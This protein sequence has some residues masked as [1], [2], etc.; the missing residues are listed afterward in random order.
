[1]RE[2]LAQAWALLLGAQPGWVLVAVVLYIVAWLAGGRR[3]QVVV[4]ALG[5]HVAFLHAALATIAGVA[6]NNVTPTG[7]VGG[8]AGRIAITR[9]R[10][11]L[12]LPRAALASV[13]DRLL[14]V[15]AAAVVLLL[16]LPALPSLAGGYLL[17]TVGGVIVLAL[18]VLVGGRW[19]RTRLHASLTEWQ[20][21]GVPLAPSAVLV[22][23]ALSLLVWSQDLLRIMAVGRAFGIPLS[24]P[25]GAALNIVGL[26][27]GFVPTIGGLG[28]V[29][30]VL[31][32]TLLLFGI[33]LENALAITALER[34]I[35]FGFST[36]LGGGVTLWFGG[37]RLWK[38]KGAADG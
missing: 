22:A 10:S 20:Q 6:I 9:L 33:P 38:G 24:V 30:G 27:G 17:A 25:Q 28:A 36:L 15:P 18:A 13:C 3:W 35:S 29:E 16:A 26:A 31:V 8:E 14:D 19:L 2:T 11:N 12:S 5:S 37:R 1:M 34:M 32:G 23:L 7:R 21:T 4:G